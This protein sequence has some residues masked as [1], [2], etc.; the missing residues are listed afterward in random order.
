MGFLE[1]IARNM[2]GGHG[3]GHGSK[4][5]SRQGGGHH[6]NAG[7]YGGHGGGYPPPSPGGLAGSG[8]ICAKCQAPGPP[9]ARFCGQ[10][11]G[12]LEAAKPVASVANNCTA[13]GAAFAPDSR[14]C[15]QCGAARP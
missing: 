13:C 14:F 11:G 6:G 10:C 15:A 7:G 12:P 2:M 9:G 4:H 1:R 3:S 5:G 8:T